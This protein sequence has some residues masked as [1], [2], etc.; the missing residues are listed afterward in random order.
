MDI[1]HLLLQKLPPNAP[2]DALLVKFQSTMDAQLSSLCVYEDFLPTI[3]VL[4]QL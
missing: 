3:E 2:I 1:A 4:K